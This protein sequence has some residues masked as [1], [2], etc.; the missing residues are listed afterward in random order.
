MSGSLVLLSGGIDSATALFLEMEHAERVATLSINYHKRN[1]REAEAARRIARAADVRECLETDLMFLREAMDLDDEIKREL[2]DLGVPLTYIPLRNL[3]FYSIGLYYA[4]VLRL[5]RVVIGH[6]AEDYSTFP[7]VSSLNLDALN[8]I[9]SRMTPWRKLRVYAPLL[10][11]SKEDVV[12]VAIE[13]KVPLGLTWSCWLEGERHC[14]EC[15]G[16]LKRRE[17][18]AKVGFSDPTEYGKS[19]P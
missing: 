8:E 3:I 17:V 18:F 16:C 5:D 15:L 11:M 12:K 13:L 4:Y 19:S 6:V 7:D 10:G 14:G 9:A 1:P 2:I